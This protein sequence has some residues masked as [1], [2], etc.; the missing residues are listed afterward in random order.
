MKVSNV[1]WEVHQG[2]IRTIQKFKWR[3][4]SGRMLETPIDIAFNL[5]S[6]LARHIVDLH[7]AALQK[8]E[9]NNGGS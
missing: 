5:G 6:E 4:T 7:N 2:G 9:L 3:T 8:Q 1:L